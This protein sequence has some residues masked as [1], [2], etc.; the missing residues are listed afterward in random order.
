MANRRTYRLVALNCRYSHSCLAL[1]Y[2]RNALETHLRDAEIT[3]LPLTINDP[4]YQSLQR[5]VEGN[6]GVLLFSA[7]IWNA[8]LLHRLVVDIARIRPG[9]PIIIGGPQAGFLGDLPDECTLVP[10]EIEGVDPSF[11]QD[12]TQGDLKPLY[13]AGEG[14]DFPFPYRAEDFSTHLHNRQI[15]YESSRGCP[16]SCSYCLSA[17]CTRVVHKDIAT[18]EDELRR[19]LASKPTLVK[20]VDR[21]FNDL[22]DRALAIWKKLVEIG[23]KTR[24]HFEVA[25]D[26]FTEEQFAFLETVPVGLFQFEIGIQST[27]AKTLAAVHRQMD[28]DRAMATIKRLRAME[29]IHL[30]VDLILGLPE[31]DRKSFADSFRRVFVCL[32]HHTQMGLLKVLPATPLAGE[33]DQHKIIH[34]ARPPH[35]V[36]ATA[37]MDNHTLADLFLFGQCVERFYNNRYFPSLWRY[38]RQS[39]ENAFVFF[40]NLLTICKERGFFQRA[41]TQEL[42]VEILVAHI[43]GRSDFELLRELLIF[44]WLRCG[45]RFLPEIFQGQ[46]LAD[47]RSR[48]RKTMP[49]GYEPLYTERERNRFF[50]QGIFY[51]FSARTL[52]LV[53]M[54]PEGDTSMVCFLEKSDGNL[55]G[56]R[57]YALLPNVFKEFP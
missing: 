34:C 35:E 21:T 30:H 33:A 49:L 10:G 37:T 32:P 2:V 47:Q 6:P 48:L 57:K 14:A 42:M 51:P 3:L 28:V 29:N 19:I 17:V 7:Y 44:D 52:R 46:S 11:Y 50:K 13:R 23:G 27:S 41:A 20:F 4:Y 36:L 24:F 53:G 54:D 1:F 22:P 45:H 26:R 39:G 38:L 43:S 8:S 55:Y 9:R 40:E 16:F 15:L 12:L 5:I 25:P 18:V 56:L 31:D